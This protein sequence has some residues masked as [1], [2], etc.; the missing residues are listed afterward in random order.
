MHDFI[1]GIVEELVAIMIHH[2]V[3]KESINAERLSKALNAAIQDAPLEPM[4]KLPFNSDTSI[5]AALEHAVKCPDSRLREVL[6]SST[7][8]LHRI[9]KECNITV[10]ELN[11]G[12]SFLTR[13]GQKCSENRQ[14]FVML[15][16][17]LGL[18]SLAQDLQLR[19]MHTHAYVTPGA[20]LGPFHK[21]GKDKYIQILD[22]TSN[23][24]DRST[25]IALRK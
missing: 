1:P 9:I 24:I 4:P 16:D 25:I 10:E 21:V 20:L 7:K 23:V 5:V 12:I 17:S 22:N 14:E 6:A 19:N 8:H 11:F 18:T 13:V 3:N 2:N 15:A